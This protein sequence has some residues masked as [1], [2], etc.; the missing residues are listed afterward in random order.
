[1]QHHLNGELEMFELKVSEN[2]L[3]LI[4]GAL[5]N[6]PYAQVAGLIE[7]IRGQ[8]AAANQTKGED[9]KGTPADE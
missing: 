8:V 2:E 9:Q 7:N 6:M 1:M 4:A 5:G 3:N